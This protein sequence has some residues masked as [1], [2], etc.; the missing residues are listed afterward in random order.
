MKIVK[1]IQLKIVI[2]FSRE[3]L[4]YIAWACFRK[5]MFNSCML[6]F[7]CLFVPQRDHEN[8]AKFML[9]LELDSNSV[10]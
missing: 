4:L 8:D 1:R 5:V 10:E 6:T 9:L 2:F 7:R 3:I